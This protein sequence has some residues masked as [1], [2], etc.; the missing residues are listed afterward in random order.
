MKTMFL[1]LRSLAVCMAAT[2]AGALAV[3]AAH[4]NPVAPAESADPFVVRAGG[5]LHYLHTTG[6]TVQIRTAAGL[7]SI[8]SGTVSTVFQAPG[9]P[10]LSDIWA[11]E[12]HFLGGK[13]YVYACGNID[14]AGG[15]HRMFVLEATTDDPTGPYAFKGLLLPDLRAIDPT[16]LVRP[17]DQARFLVYSGY[18]ADGQCLYVAP[19]ADPWTVGGAPVRIA[20]PAHSWEKVGAPINEGPA[21]LQRGGKTFIVFSASGSWTPDYCL[22]MLVH[23]GGDYLDP[24]SWVK[25]AQPVFQR[26]DANGVYCVGHN[27]FVTSPS[28]AEDWIVYHGTSDPT[29][30]QFPKRST[31]I[32]RF[33]WNPD[34]TPRF[35]VP[36]P[37]GYVM[38]GPDE[39]AAEPS[40]QAHYAFEGN[41]DDNSGQARNGSLVGGTA[42]VAG[43]VDAGAIAFDGTGYAT[44]PRSV[45]ND[46]TIALWVKTTDS[47]NDGQWWAG[48]GL[49]DGDVS[50]AA[51]DFG[52]SLVGANAAF[53]VGNP[54]TTIKST[55]SI[56]DGQWHHVLATRTATTGAMAVYVDGNLEAS[57]TGPAG[58]RAAPAVLRVGGILTSGGSRFLIG[59]IDEV[60]LYD[61]VL[62]AGEIAAVAAGQAAVTLVAHYA[63]DGDGRDGAGQANDG[64]PVGIEYVG[65]RV[66]SQAARFDGSRSW[67]R[68]PCPVV[69]SFSIAFWVKTLDT[70]GSGQ[71]WSGKGMVDAEVGG[72]AADFGVSLA[73]SHAAFGAGSS[74]VTVTSAATINDG[75]W[76]HVVATRD[77]GTGQMVVYVDGV[78]DGS[79][80]GPAGARTAPR[81]LHIGNLQTGQ[82]F[83]TGTLDDVRLC[84]GVLAA[85]AV[86]AL[87]ASAGPP[88]PAEPPPP[89]APKTPPLATPWTA[90]VSAASVL[91]EY[92]RP[93]MVR[94][95]WLNL[96]G[97]WQI[98][99]DS[100]GGTSP[101]FGQNLAASIL[102]PFPTE[103]ALSGIMQRMSRIWY[104]RTFEVPAGWAGRRVLLN[105][106]AVD[107]QATVYVN[108]V[109]VGTHAGGYDGFAF[110]V[111]DQLH[112]G[113]NELVV[114][115]YDPTDGDGVGQPIGKQRAS[116]SGIW[117]TSC[118]GIWQTVWLEPVAPAHI[119]RLEITPDIDN[120]TVAVSALC[121]GTTGEAVR[122]V[123]SSGGVEVARAT[124]VPGGPLTIALPDPHLWSPD[125]P[126]LYDLEVS[127]LDGATPVDAVGSYFGMRKISLGVA[128]GVLR[129]LL[130]NNFVF[131][132]G[133]LD[134]GFWPDGVYTAP[135]DDA[136]RFDIEAQKA[137]GC[138]VIRKHVKVEPA[139]WY[140]WADKLGMLVW[141]DMPSK[142]ETGGAAQFELELAAMVNQLRNSPAIV[143]WVP[144]NEG[145]GQYDTERITG[146]VKSWDPSRLVNNASG[147][148]DAGAGDVIDWH[149]YLGPGSP[150]P[151]TTRAAVLGE[152]GGLGL[153]VV[154]HEWNP[155]ASF[156]YEMQADSAALTSRYVGLLYDTRSLMY[157]KGLSA[158]IYTAITDVENELDGHWT[159]DRQV[160]KVDPDAVRAVHGSLIEAS[161]SQLDAP[162]VGAGWWKLDENA[163]TTAADSS[164]NDNPAGLA[165]AP[166]WVAGVDGAALRFDGRIGFAAVERPVLDT[167]ADYSVSAWVKLE[168]T[169]NWATAVSQDGANVSGFLLQYSQSV[170]R[171]TMTV[172]EWDGTDS[173]SVRAV[174]PAAPVL[175]QWVH[176][177]GVRD[178]THGELRLY[179]DGVLADTESCA[180]TW[181]A[182]GSTVIGRARWGNSADFFPGAIDDVRVVNRALDAAD[183]A[184]LHHYPGGPMPIPG[185]TIGDADGDSLP[186]DWESTHGLDRFDA[187]GD[188]GAGGDPDHDGIPNLAEYVLVGDPRVLSALILPAVAVGPGGCTFTFKRCAA[189]AQTI[190]QTFQYGDDLV[191][192]NDIPIAPGA[193]V[194][195]GDIDGEGNQTVVV[196]LPADGPRLFGR[197]RLTVP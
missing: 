9:G 2:M 136:L 196:T 151:S 5:L 60:R 129:P 67:V 21:V 123:V 139:R 77:G 14:P 64:V 128:G 122:A 172:P 154:G 184:W 53:G 47:G 167:G 56:N 132:I 181:R 11:P 50:S 145:W 105:F 182:R 155:A 29:G 156:G 46:F 189:S 23:N 109:Q 13:W 7:E 17:A 71:W 110:D 178:V 140:Y 113:G 194:A 157:G 33:G 62:T 28:G 190:G 150:V 68:T 22:G 85:D 19:L 65:G 87:Y 161:R 188:Q 80:T 95:E 32:Q 82:N 69:D 39:A 121:S 118:S 180:A 91:P 101:P 192:W 44:I 114:G 10:I 100:S 79:A 89:W 187:A 177:V 138:N 97:E 99:G 52:L 18:D 63:F 191:R 124:G 59:S 27:S 1:P 49:V 103:S 158:A 35:G 16:I 58:W 152:F 185:G 126:F 159:Y 171:L 175:G 162:P 153:K 104:R 36:V 137:F 75:L 73:G 163:G 84:R 133:M 195:I 169:A 115:V 43:K 131:Q 55:T 160:L 146:L 112:E 117:Y 98:G 142:F 179:V 174:A 76:H 30:D 74:D 141:Q 57:G 31:R 83:F 120:G 38:P 106:G 168:S 148:T 94:G 4:T 45:D 15:D 125:D 96:N 40:L 170:G 166:Q 6:S 144:F 186:D 41:A 90:Q 173:P 135:T 176:L 51:D 26:W 143:M 165:N 72:V 42:T 3:R 119:A 20:L 130:N 116:P 193:N 12:L 78:A 48:K 127:L 149:V 92:P 66:G 111:T 93:Q 134:Q 86:A 24:A 164:G 37:V 197:L 108:G 81:S 54:D 34:G 8:G 25:Q 102:V 61:R 70:G 183:A 88:P 147:W 107:W